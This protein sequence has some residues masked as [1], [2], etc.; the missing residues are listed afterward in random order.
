LKFTQEGEVSVKV[1]TKQVAD[2]QNLEV[3][4]KDTGIGIPEDEMESIFLPFTQ[5]GGQSVN[6]YGGTGSGLALARGLVRVMN[7]TLTVESELG[8]GSVFKLVIENIR[9]KERSESRAS[10]LSDTEPGYWSSVGDVPGQAL[11]QGDNREPPYVADLRLSKSTSLITD[12]ENLS[13]IK[14][15]PGLIAAM[16]AERESVSAIISVCAINEIES[17][18]KMMKRIAENH[19]CAALDRWSNELIDAAQKFDLDAV[20]N[21]LPRYDLLISMLKK[22]AK[23]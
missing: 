5:V 23:K 19:E 17:A 4:I 13:A 21:A 22:R 14:D 6:E 7:G 2:R 1:K 3:T 16:G 18:G 11:E 9:S 10:N 20:A 8:K 15:I 12:E